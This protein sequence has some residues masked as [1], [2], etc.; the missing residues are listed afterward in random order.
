MRVTPLVKL[1]VMTPS[2]P[3]EKSARVPS[4][5]PS[6]PVIAIDERVLVSELISSKSIVMSSGVTA[7][8]PERSIEMRLPVALRSWPLASNVSVP[9]AT[10]RSPL[11]LA[12]EST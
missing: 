10:A 4:G 7:P 5:A 6:C 1:P 12:G 9:V 8:A 11:E 2:V 3:I